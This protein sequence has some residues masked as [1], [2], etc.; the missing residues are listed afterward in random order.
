MATVRVSS[1]NGSTGREGGDSSDGSR[2]SSPSLVSS[3]YLERPEPEGGSGPRSPVGGGERVINGISLFLLQ[4]GIVIDA[5]RAEP[6]SG[7]PVIGGYDWASHEVGS[8]ESEFSTQEELRSWAE[9]SFI[10]SPWKTPHSACVL[11]CFNS[12]FLR[13]STDYSTGCGN[14]HSTV[15]ELSVL[16]LHLEATSTCNS[17]GCETVHSLVVELSSFI[18]ELSTT[19]QQLK[20]TRARSD[21]IVEEA[22]R[23]KLEAKG[24]TE[25]EKELQSHVERTNETI[26]VLNTNVQIEH[27]EDFNKALR[28]TAFLLGADPLAV[29]FDIC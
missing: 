7:W 14:F 6:A 19:V 16:Q 5:E 27:E 13:E 25:S 18:L 10:A 26:V 15:V 1:S 12:V 21:W 11:L 3:S 8:Y 4:V 29:D 22:E 24:L 23:L 20:E 17:T 9:R 2:S 28:Q